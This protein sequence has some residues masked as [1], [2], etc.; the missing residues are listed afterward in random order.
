MSET[1]SAP[2]NE[3]RPATLTRKPVIG[4]YPAPPSL[5]ITSSTFPRRSPAESRSGLPTTEE[6]WRIGGACVAFTALIVRASGAAST[7]QTLDGSRERAG[8]EAPGR[9]APRRRTRPVEQERRRDRDVQ[10]R[11]QRVGL[12]HL[13]RWPGRSSEV[14]PL[15]R[16]AA[17]TAPATTAVT[18]SAAT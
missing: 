3:V 8:V 16:I 18:S 14:L 7:Q 9:E 10:A 6:R 17:I 11:C 5:T 12:R 15:V 1:R 13:A 4:G 2:R